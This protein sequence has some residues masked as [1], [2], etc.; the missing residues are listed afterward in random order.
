MSV[1][2]YASLGGDPQT[3]HAQDELYFAH[4]GHRQ[5]RFAEELFSFE[6]GSAFFVAAA[7]AHRFEN[8]SDDF[9][10]GWSFGGQGHL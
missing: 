2:L 6:P 5:F 7:V 4:S 3:P 9:R 1:D 8:F 10:L